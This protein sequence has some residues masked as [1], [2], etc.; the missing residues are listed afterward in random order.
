MDKWITYLGR[1]SRDVEAVS[2]V[3]LVK[4]CCFCGVVLRLN[5]VQGCAER[6]V[7]GGRFRKVG[8]V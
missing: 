2:P 5:M 8:C 4:C 7:D 3:V 1:S 6:R